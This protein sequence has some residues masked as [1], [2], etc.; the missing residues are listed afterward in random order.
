MT[1]ISNFESLPDELLLEVC[2]YLLCVDVL[3]SFDNLNTRM[4]C[5][6][7]DYY[8]HVS[9]HKAS[10]TQSHELC[11]KILPNIGAQI[12]TLIIDNFYS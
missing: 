2:K 9:L 3:F 12:K 10:Y 6:I 11:S 5:M 8:R 7:S 1:S 4:T